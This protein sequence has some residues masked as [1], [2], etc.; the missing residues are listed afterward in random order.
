MQYEKHVASVVAWTNLCLLLNHTRCISEDTCGCGSFHL[1]TDNVMPA[2]AGLWFDYEVRVQCIYCRLE[3]SFLPAAYRVSVDWNNSEQP[4]LTRL[5]KKK[6]QLQQIT[7]GTRATGSEGLCF[8]YTLLSACRNISI[9][10]LFFFYCSIY[11]VL[12]HMKPRPVIK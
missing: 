8:C 4:R 11:F 3:D 5:S 9:K 2:H 7:T 6:F 1:Q 12:L 10:C